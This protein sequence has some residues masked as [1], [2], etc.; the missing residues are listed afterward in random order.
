[1]IHIYTIITQKIKTS[2]DMYGMTLG[3]MFKNMFDLSFFF[4]LL[5][6]MTGMI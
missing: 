3:P 4:Y 5:F 6:A 1:M 2:G